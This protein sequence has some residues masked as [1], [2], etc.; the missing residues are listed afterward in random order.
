MLLPYL[1][2]MDGRMITESNLPT[3]EVTWRIHR[4]A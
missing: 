4:I 2:K 3:F 1:Q